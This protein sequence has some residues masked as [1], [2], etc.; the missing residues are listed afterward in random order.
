[1]PT[2]ETIEKLRAFQ[3]QI[4]D[5]AERRETE[6]QAHGEVARVSTDDRQ[7]R[8]E[9]E[10]AI[11]DTS[12]ALTLRAIGDLTSLVLEVANTRESDSQV[13]SLMEMLR[14]LDDRLESMEKSP[15]RRAPILT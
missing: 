11:A 12:V 3:R 14:S 5:L 8:A 10:T 9:L 2:A 6:G 7:A 13:A 15:K 4:N 1:M